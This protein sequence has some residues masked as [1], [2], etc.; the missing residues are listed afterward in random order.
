MRQTLHCT[1]DRH[2]EGRGTYLVDEGGE[3]VVECLD[4]LFL[5]GTDHLDGWVDSQV[6]GGQ[7]ALVDLDSGDLWGNAAASLA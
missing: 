5:L 3:A 1:S 2:T 7:Q 6:Q 4:L